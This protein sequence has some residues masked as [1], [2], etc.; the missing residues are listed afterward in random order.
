MLC[1]VKGRDEYGY[2]LEGVD[3]VPERKQDLKWKPLYDNRDE[4]YFHKGRIESSLAK[5]VS[6]LKE[7]NKRAD[8]WRDNYKDLLHKY[9]KLHRDHMDLKYGDLCSTCQMVSDTI[10]PG[11]TITPYDACGKGKQTIVSK[12]S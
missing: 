7:S 5:I 6:L 3:L 9:D 4:E 2:V 1:S 12:E 8:Q 11:K 10:P